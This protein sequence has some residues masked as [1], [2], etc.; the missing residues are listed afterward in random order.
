M[1]ATATIA[2][3]TTTAGTISAAV[4]HVVTVREASGRHGRFEIVLPNGNH[5]SLRASRTPFLTA[6]RYLLAEGAN[7]DA[8]IEMRHAARPDVI[9]LSGRLGTVAKLDV[10]EG[11]NGPRFHKWRPPPSWAELR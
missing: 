10:H 9:A 11:P 3:I 4:R 8:V 2:H 6:A 1:T 5:P 7:P